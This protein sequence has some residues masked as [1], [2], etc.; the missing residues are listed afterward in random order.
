MISTLIRRFY[1]F[2]FVLTREEHTARFLVEGALERLSP[3]LLLGSYASD[4]RA[5]VVGLKD[6]YQHFQQ[7]PVSA[8]HSEHQ[9]SWV[10]SLP[11][12]ERIALFLQI[13]LGWEVECIALFLNCNQ[14]EVE[15]YLINARRT[16]RSALHL[17]VPAQIIPFPGRI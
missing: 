10:F 14:S 15:K 2:A 4:T 16:M 9:D 11:I 7:N 5:L 6:I 8:N 12:G 13:H 1:R 17:R 3:C